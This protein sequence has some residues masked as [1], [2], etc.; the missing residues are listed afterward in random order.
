MRSARVSSASPRTLLGCAVLSHVRRAIT[1]AGGAALCVRRLKAHQ[2]K[3][4]TAP[5]EKTKQ[6]GSIPP[7]LLDR[8]EVNRAKVTQPAQ[9][10]TPGA[11]ATAWAAD[12]CSPSA[13]WV[14]FAHTQPFALPQ[15]QCCAPALYYDN[16]YMAAL[17]VL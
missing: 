7:Y 13:L 5:D 1:E 15:N 9:P 16:S 4:A 12:S 14:P 3:N 17:L 8:G 11:L 6:E 2:E 10:A